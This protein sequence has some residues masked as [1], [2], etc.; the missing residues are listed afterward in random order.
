[1][2]MHII[3]TVYSPS[4]FYGFSFHDER[5]LSLNARSK[6]LSFFTSKFMSIAIKTSMNTSDLKLS[7]IRL[8]FTNCKILFTSKKE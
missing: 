6:A 8:G 1:M 4:S 7:V 3:D 2:V 5:T